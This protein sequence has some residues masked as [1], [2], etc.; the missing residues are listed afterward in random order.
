MKNMKNTIRIVLLT[1]SIVFIYSSCNVSFL[2]KAPLNE[3]SD[4]TF[5]TKEADAV[6]AVNAVYDPMQWIHAY[7][8]TINELSNEF[9]NDLGLPR[10][11]QFPS[12][13]QPT[14]TRELSVWPVLY[15]GI[16]RANIAIEKIPEIEMDENLKT[17]LLAEVKFLRGFYYFKLATFFGDV[18]I[19]D[20]PTTI[21]NLEKAKS[22]KSD[23]IAFV[24]RD[25]GEAIAGLPERSD[26][27]TSDLGR[28][29]KGAAIALLGKVELYEK[30]FAEAAILFKKVIDSQEYMLNEDYGPQFNYGGDN[31]PES[32]FEV[33]FVTNSGGAW[34][35]ESEGGYFSGWEGTVQDGFNYGFG[36]NQQPNQD[37]VDAFEVGDNRKDYIIVEDGDDYFGTPFNGGNSTTGYG[38]RKYIIPAELETGGAADSGINQ[39]IIRY[40]DVLL[41]YAEAVNETS[42]G[43]NTDALDAINLVRERAGL[44]DLASGLSKQDFFDAIVHERRIEL[45]MEDQRLW[46]LIRWGLAPE[47]LGDFNGF[48]EGRHETLPIPQSEIDNNPLMVQN[49]AYQ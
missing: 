40:A 22:P 18:I 13:F 34:G 48:V 7:K 27:P 8:I 6:A 49:P 17:R 16:N 41:M 28:A 19:R 38:F 11:D 10:P 4:A 29:T 20:E 32:I 45:F 25:L 30:N 9:T 43:P 39:H 31:T 15:V 37:F 23:V 47:I 33:Q 42:N 44:N 5:Y 35:N 1:M 26:Q 36:A 3:A 12:M 14:V 46:D 21:N 2:D 24:R